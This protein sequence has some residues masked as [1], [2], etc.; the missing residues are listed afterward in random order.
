MLALLAPSADAVLNE[1]FGFQLREDATI[2]A[3]PLQYHGGPV[4][5]SSDAYTIY[6]DPTG[7]YR[8]DWKRLINQYFQN[9]GT[10]SGSLGNVFALNSQYGDASGGASNQSTFRGGYT[11]EDPYPTTGNCSE[12]SSI[13]CLTDA[14]IRT[15]LQHVI[16]SGALPG[17]TGPAVYYVLTPPEVIVCTDAGGNGNC[18]NSTGSPPDGICGYHSAIGAGGSNPV[19]YAVQP[20]VAGKAGLIIESENPTKTSGFTP[21]DLACQAGTEPLEE[22]NQLEGLNPF[23]NYAE[24]LADVII[25][26]L[27]V[28]QS[29]IVVDPLLNGWYQTATDAEQGDMCQRNFGSPPETPPTPNALT[30][31][32]NLSNETINGASYYIPWAFNSTGLTTGRGFE[33]W[34]GDSFEPYFTAPNPVNTGDVV[35][36]DATESNITLLAS[37]KGLPADEPYVVPS[38]KWEFGDGTEV[39]GSKDASVFHSYTYGGEYEVTLTVTDSGRNSDSFSEV[40][41]VDGPAPPAP[42]APPTPAPSTP[43]TPAATPAPP[44][45][46][47]AAAKPTATQTAVSHSLSSVLKGGLVVHYSVN[48]QVAGRFEVLLARSIAKKIG[49]HGPAATGLAKGSPA[50][51]V[52]AKAILVTTKGG[53]SSYKIK[54]SKATAAH[55]RKLHKVSLMIRMVVHNAASPVATTV[56]STVNLAH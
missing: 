47:A 5:H 21:E 13:A 16:A 26:D 23:G 55:L 12:S 1:G 56:L 48:E 44:V 36:F 15:E 51:I 41:T 24:G 38:Y 28:E 50:Q 14:Q 30:H 35:A 29:N 20:W 49:L 42:P 31:A 43:A 37:A 39:S 4:L 45:S 2:K 25:G 46:P 18:S 53:H 33:C 9:V 52:I 8:G 34:S 54:F 32:A 11:D 27:A 3:E 40:I 22:P 10:D 17:A 19:I 6:W 7:T